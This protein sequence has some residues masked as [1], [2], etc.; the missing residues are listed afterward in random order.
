MFLFILIHAIY[1][2]LLNGKVSR[3]R[4]TLPC[5]LHLIDNCYIKTDRDETVSDLRHKACK[6]DKFSRSVH[7]IT[8][9]RT[10]SEASA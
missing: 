2:F 1:I 3:I 8:K 9:H 10:V 7:R 4:E 6:V 5:I